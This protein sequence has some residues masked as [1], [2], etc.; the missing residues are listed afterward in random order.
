VGRPNVGKSTL[1]NR[2][3][4]RREAVVEDVP[5]V[6]RDR[7]AYDATWNG[8]RFT[9]LDTGGWQR[10]ARGMAGR[11]AE[12]AELA[13]TAADAVVLVVD[14]TVGVTEEDAAVA[15][16]LQR[17][18]RPV[19]LAANKVDDTRAEAA[20]AELWQLGV[21]EPMPV[22]ALHGRG[23]GDLL[24][25]ILR[26]L[27]AAPAD[28]E[29][30]ERGPRRVALVGRP[31]VGKSSLLNRLAG[32]ERALVDPEAGTTRDPVDSLVDLDG[33][34]WRFVDTAGLRRRAREAQG[35]DYYATLRTNAAIEAAEVA[36]VLLD[37]DTPITEQD[38]RVI[39][40][41]VDA[42]RAL[43]LAFNKADLVD[44]D[45]R[46]EIDRETE[47]EL[48]R[49]PWASRINVSAKTGRG[50]Q[51]IAAALE[52]ALAG[53]ETRVATAELNAFLGDVVAATP[54]PVR[55]GK[56]PKILFAT[57]P[58]V[59]P[60]RFVLFTSG[61]L[62]ASYRRFLERRLRERY[63]FHGSPIDISVRAREKKR[64]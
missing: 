44:A 36:L 1:V 40:M 31:N 34:I 6:T 52:E 8:R 29:P 10:D 43:V 42:G 28:R 15:K 48:A 50:V 3:I 19:L 23:S 55:G 59:A 9:V 58:G 33:A 46:A 56:Q 53:W 11:I 18:R 22:S 64:R 35:A 13:V 4:G 5:G 51:R 57:Q 16:V 12:Q 27:P 41:V 45:R 30:T 14:A 61:P 24:D 26:M 62:E 60:P 7:V 37:S 38:Q 49:V 32:T 47:R 63:G 39:S 17:A 54:P 21:G 25:A 20:T 2:V